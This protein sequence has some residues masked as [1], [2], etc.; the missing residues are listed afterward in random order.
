MNAIWVVEFDEEQDICIISKCLPEDY[1][2]IARNK[3]GNY[4]SAI[5]KPYNGGTSI[6]M[7]GA[8]EVQMD[9]MCL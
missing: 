4:F 9:T 2:L 8:S 5:L 3:N 1:L 6:K 7:I